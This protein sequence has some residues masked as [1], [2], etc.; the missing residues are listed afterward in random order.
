[1][2]NSLYTAFRQLK[3]YCWIKKLNPFFFSSNNK[4]FVW[5]TKKSHLNRLRR[6]VPQSLVV[7]MGWRKDRDMPLLLYGKLFFAKVGKDRGGIGRDESGVFGT[8]TE[9]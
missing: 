6:P 4:M 3:V 1:M 5:I 2:F 7:D 9:I 8:T